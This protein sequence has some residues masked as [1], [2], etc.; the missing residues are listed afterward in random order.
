[1]KESGAAPVFETARFVV[2]TSDGGYAF[3]ATDWGFVAGNETL[4]AFR[5]DAAGRLDSSCPSQ[6]GRR[7]K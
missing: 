5:T 2:Q 1:M 4:L 3:S 7:T 6:S